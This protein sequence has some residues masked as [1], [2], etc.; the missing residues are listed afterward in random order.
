MPRFTEPFIAELLSRTDLVALVSEYI[1][2]EAKGR[3]FWGCCPFHNEKTPSFRYI[4]KNN[5]ITVLVA[6]PAEALY[7][8]LWRRKG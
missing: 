5:Y 4:R 8:L 1:R 3:R 6:M 7:S 2:L